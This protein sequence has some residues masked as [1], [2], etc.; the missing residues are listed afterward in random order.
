LIVENVQQN[1]WT[2][3]LASFSTAINQNTAHC[4]DFKMNDFKGTINHNLINP[5]TN[6]KYLGFHSDNKLT[7]KT[8][9]NSLC[10]KLSNLC[11]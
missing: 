3:L 4:D 7:W 6:V 11:L 10:K 8:H 2:H 9:I 5:G 1:V